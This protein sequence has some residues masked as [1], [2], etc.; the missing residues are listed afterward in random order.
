MLSPLPTILPV[1]FSPQAI[2]AAFRTDPTFAA[3]AQKEMEMIVAR[4]E[5][6]GEKLAVGR[7]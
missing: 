6:D 1:L 3:F 4:D 7:E 5:E 2:I